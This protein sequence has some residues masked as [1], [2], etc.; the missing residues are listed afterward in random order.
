MNWANA[1]NVLMS[2]FE[3][4]A[5]TDTLYSAVGTK[6]CSVTLVLDVCIVV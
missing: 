4:M 6:S 3:L 5:A 2:P 1:E